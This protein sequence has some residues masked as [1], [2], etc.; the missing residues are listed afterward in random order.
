[1]EFGFGLLHLSEETRDRVRRLLLGSSTLGAR[2]PPL[3][4]G[5]L[6]GRCLDFIVCTDT[7]VTWSLG[8]LFLGSFVAS[9]RV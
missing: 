2:V 6:H 8:G 4:L 1:M 3:G 7:W 9:R 5:G